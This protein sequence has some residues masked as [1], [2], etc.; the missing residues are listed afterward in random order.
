MQLKI[1]AQLVVLQALGDG[2]GHPL[3]VTLQV[4]KGHLKIK[5]LHH[6]QHRRLHALQ[7]GVVS[8][9]GR[10]FVRFGA[11]DVLGADGR[12]HKNKVVLEI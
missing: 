11:F 1:G 12:A 7:A 5:I 4:P 3:G 2:A 9:V 8:A 6:L 10:A